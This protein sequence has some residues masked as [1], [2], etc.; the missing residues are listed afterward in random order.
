MNRGAAR[1]AIFVG[2]NDRTL[3]LD[4]LAQATDE[5]K[6]EAHAY[7]LMNNHFHLLVRSRD[8]RLSEFLKRLSGRYTRLVN[9]RSG[10]DGPLFKGRATSILITSDAQ[11]VQTS[12]YIHLNPVVAGLCRWPEEWTWSSARTYLGLEQPEAWLSTYM[13]LNIFVRTAPGGDYRS[14]LREG[15]DLATVDLYNRLQWDRGN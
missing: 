1:Q 9:K 8:A 15:V 2:E 4:C 5:A 13:I 14:F 7:C 11:L 3:F 6:V 12:R 10:R